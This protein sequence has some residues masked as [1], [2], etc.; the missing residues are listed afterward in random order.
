MPTGY[1]VDFKSLAGN[2]GWGNVE[3]RQGH[4]GKAAI[5]AYRDVGT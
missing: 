2:V 1:L 3:G 4:T 5:P